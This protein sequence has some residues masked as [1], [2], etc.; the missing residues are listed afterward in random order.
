[1]VPGILQLFLLFEKRLGAVGII[2][3]AL[4]ES[5]GK[6]RKLDACRSRF[7]KDLH[8]DFIDATD[9]HLFVSASFLGGEGLMLLALGGP[10]GFGG[11]NKP[12]Q[13]SLRSA[14]RKGLQFGDGRSCRFVPES[15]GSGIHRIGH[16]GR[17][18]G[19]GGRRILCVCREGS[20]CQARENERK[21]FAHTLRIKTGTGTCPVRMPVWRPRQSQSLGMIK[22]SRLSFLTN[23]EGEFLGGMLCYPFSRRVFSQPRETRDLSISA[24]VNL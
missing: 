21:R 10:A 1:M 24:T 17:S 16:R 11:E 18:V 12:C 3:K 19:R 15:L 13:F 4:L 23:A 14:S 9:G 8:S 22:H 7:V 20:R 6:L 5:R 2:A